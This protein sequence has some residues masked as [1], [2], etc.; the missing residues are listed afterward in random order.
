MKS[1]HHRLSSCQLSAGS[2]YTRRH[3]N[4]VHIH[5]FICSKLWCGKGNKWYTCNS[6]LIPENDTIRILWNFPIQQPFQ[7]MNLIFY[8]MARLK[9]YF[10]RMLTYHCHMIPS[11]R[12]I[13]DIITLIGKVSSI[14]SFKSLAKLIH[15]TLGLTSI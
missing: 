12:N 4:A 3:N 10:W 15:M 9:L 14:A 6:A 5:W 1:I 2:L 13:K 8:Y 11:Y 7:Q